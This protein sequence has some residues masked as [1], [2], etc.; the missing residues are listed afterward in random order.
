MNATTD[1]AYK[2]INTRNELEN[3]I[4]AIENEK[5]VG[6]D[7]EADSMYHFQEKVCLIQMAATNINVVIDPLAIQDLSPLKPIFKRSDICKIFH[8]ADYDVR[9]LYRDFHITIHNLFDTELAS[10]FLGVPETGLEAVLKKKF[11]VTLDKKFQRKDWSR[12]PLPP[13]MIAYAAEDARYLLPL[14]QGLNAELDERN[15]L[16]WVYEECEYLSRVRPITVNDQPLYLN[17]KGAGKLDS[18]SLAVLENLLGFRREVA[19]RKDKPLFRIFGNRSLMELAGKKPLN[20][21]QLEKTRALSSR[22]ISMYGRE[23]LAAIQGAMN[24]PAKELPVYPRKKSPRISLAV[25]GRVK[26]LRTWRDKQ[27]QKLAI[28]P[29][30]I[31]NKALMSTIAVQRPLN[32]SE[33]AAIKEM[34]NWQRKEFGQDIVKVLRKE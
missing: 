24:L 1:I 28:D 32:L 34:K 25:A 10:R 13:D 18:R 6:V 21:K 29:A 15:R 20:L 22:Q 7:L 12:R 23:M 31:C 9:S 16:G 5:A 26:A 2:M 11:A 19:R 14:A 17:F 27:A 33:L 30:L 8:G 4:G 3:L